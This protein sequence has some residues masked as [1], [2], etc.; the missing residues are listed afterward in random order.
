MGKVIIQED[1]MPDLEVNIPD[2]YAKKVF[3]DTDN[4]IRDLRSG[5]LKQCRKKLCGPTER[6]SYGFCCLGVLSRLQ[7]RLTIQNSKNNAW[8]DGATEAA[9]TTPNAL[10]PGNPFSKLTSPLGN[11]RPVKVMCGVQD[12]SVLSAINDKGYSFET[13]AKVIELCF[14]S[15]EHSGTEVGTEVPVAKKE[16]QKVQEQPVDTGYPD[17]PPL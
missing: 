2:G 13:I 12:L 5:Q 1:G 9:L 14:T 6:G 11:L 3:P 16:E 10:E 4:W 7:G 8:V 17:L 15:G